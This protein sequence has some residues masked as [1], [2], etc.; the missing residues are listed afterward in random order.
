MQVVNVF[1]SILSNA[2]G[3]NPFWDLEELEAR[4]LTF[5]LR[6]GSISICIFFMP[7]NAALNEVSA[8][9]WH[10]LIRYPAKAD[11]IYKVTK[12]F[13]LLLALVNCS[14]ILLIY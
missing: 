5:G 4:L 9:F 12:Q 8:A 13:G 3:N 1:H 7:H 10:V 11:N 2:L 14:A 6:K